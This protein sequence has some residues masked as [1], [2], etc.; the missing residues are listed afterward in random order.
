[1]VMVGLNVWSK[2][3]L[4]MYCAI[5]GILVGAAV[6]AGM[7]E[8]QGSAFSAALSAGI[9]AFPKWSARLPEFRLDLVIP[10]TIT[11]L[12]CCLR[13]MGDITN[14]QRINDRDWVRPDMTSIRNGLFADGATTMVSAFLGSVGGNTFSASVG[15]SSATGV[16]S[17]RISLWT[18]GIF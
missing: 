6:A 14:A 17:R 7:G 2:G 11:A 4:R 12:A 5:I 15:L 18:G 16:T 3:G 9:V 13:A 8:A 1:A 10:F